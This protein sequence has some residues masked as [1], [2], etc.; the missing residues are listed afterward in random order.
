MHACRKDTDHLVGMSRVRQVG[1]SGRIR[2]RSSSTT[3]KC[4]GQSDLL[5]KISAILIETVPASERFILKSTTP[6]R[7]GRSLA[8]AN[9]PKSLSSVTRILFSVCAHSRMA[10]SSIRVL[11]AS[12][13]SPKKNQFFCVRDG[14][15]YGA[16]HPGVK[17]DSQDG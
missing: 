2:I 5:S 10:R 13:R 12:L 7:E 17:M 9:S 4:A 6:H 3:E 14:V 1:E 15:A 16:W 11:S 8:K